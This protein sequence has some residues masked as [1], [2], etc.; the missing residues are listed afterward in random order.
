MK[1]VAFIRRFISSTGISGVILHK[2]FKRSINR[3]FC[4]SCLC[5]IDN[6]NFFHDKLITRKFKLIFIFAFKFYHE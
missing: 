4:L 3:A 5:K 1:L 2:R 6:Q